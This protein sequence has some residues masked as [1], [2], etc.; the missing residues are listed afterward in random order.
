MLLT[1]EGKEIDL[2]RPWGHGAESDN[3]SL[4]FYTLMEISI[5]IT[6][7]DGGTE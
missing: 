1:L 6:P 2:W 4:C 3:I 7:Y 5:L